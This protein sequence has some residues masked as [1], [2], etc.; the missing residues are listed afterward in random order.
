MRKG[1]HYY[2]YSVIISY[3]YRLK[4]ELI[5]KNIISLIFLL[6][7]F[8][9]LAQDRKFQGKITGKNTGD[10]LV[11]ANVFVVES[12]K[13][14]T[15]DKEGFYTIS[16]PPGK[17][18]LR[19]SYVGYRTKD[20]VVDSNSSLLQNIELQESGVLNELVVSAK[21]KD[22]NITKMNLGVE[23][24]SISEI[25]A[26]PALM[27]EVDVIKAIQLLPGVQSTSEGGSGF[28]VRGGSPDQNLIVL[29]NTTLY[30]PSHLM[31]FFSI[32]NN[33]VI[34]GIELYK[35]DL[36]F[37]VGGRLS[38]LLDVRTKDEIPEH[39]SGT[40]GVG[41]ISSRLMLE[42]PIGEKTSYLVGGR[43]SY[44][45][46]FL[47]LS[48]D[49]DIRSA[50]LYFY[51]MNFKINHRFSEKDKL[52]FNFYYGLDKFGAQPGDFK[53]GN[54][55]GSLTWNHVFSS[56]LFGK[57]SINY[58][59]YDYGLA[60]H[61]EGAEMEWKSRIRDWMLRA[62]FHQPLNDLWDL[63][64][65]ASSIYH[66]FDPG[67]V[68]ISD[69][70]DYSVPGSEALEHAVY[71][72][73]EQKFSY[74]FSL[75]YGLRFSLFQNIGDIKHH[76]SALEPGI[77]AV[78]RIDEV[79]SVKANYR[80]NTQ[81]MQLANNSAS[82]SPLDVWFS[83]SPKIK[84][85]QADLFSVGYFRNFNDNM[86][87]TSAEIYYKDL[88]NVID[89]AEHAILIMNENLEDEVRTGTGKAYGLELMAKKNSGRLTG[90]VNYTLSRSERTIPE[91]NNGK[92][93]LAPY[94]KTHAVNIVAN[95]DFSEKLNFSATW[96]FAS[97]TPTTYPTGRFEIDGEYFPIYSGR[98][99]YR[100]PNYHRLDLSLNYIPNPNST[101]RWK[102]E[103]NFS[104]YNAY[105]K[106][107]PWTIY[108]DQ[109]DDSGMP[110]AEMLYLFGIVP[111]ISYNFKF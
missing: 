37:N 99:E 41:L 102:G 89:F 57:F 79:S 25:K 39:F 21:Q 104:I 82:G 2:N 68:Q 62:D 76:Y 107:N 48:S 94:D 67:M 3:F 59:D 11:G 109:D 6:L 36:P 29:D 50:V 69:L 43:R 54:G 49:E 9:V 1:T 96:V 12:K 13:G 83:A 30:N 110:Y 4:N 90:F 18:T 24:L 97:G 19:F 93:Y 10:A 7:S 111:S 17:F 73:N 40:G 22:E 56:N 27:G 47:K 65:G 86:Y 53:Y 46:L 72:S 92:T 88:K 26:L 34:S 28:S 60:T 84:P 38:S 63:N 74:R 23:K 14:T 61:L 33:D 52:A 70:D 64:Y 108:Y 15:S 71:L 101:K 81:Y 85:Q 35:G 98:N 87:E 44:A 58:T 20:L 91:V 106:K 42:G 95:Y 105:N 100:K 31:G 5:L 8:S 78:F 51:D 103:W 16:L 75:R 32:F 66:K 45:D 77:G 80:R 55:A